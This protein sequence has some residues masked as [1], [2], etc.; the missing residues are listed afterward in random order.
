MVLMCSTLM[1]FSWSQG[2]R[3]DRPPR[4][5]IDRKGAHDGPQPLHLPTLLVWGGVDNL[6]DDF[7]RTQ[8]G[9]RQD[10]DLARSLV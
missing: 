7:S 10:E 6:A 9:L 5:H 3:F 1:K 2:W 4:V 8:F